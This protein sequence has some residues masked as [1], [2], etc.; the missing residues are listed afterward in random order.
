[1]KCF[2]VSF[3]LLL[4]YSFPSF[5]D[6]KVV[7][8]AV[9][10]WEPYTS[11]LSDPELKIS[12]TLVRRAFEVRGY[13]VE[14][15][16]YPWVRS[17]QYA[18]RGKFDGTFPWMKNEDRVKEFIFSEPFFSQRVQFFYHSDTLFSW[19]EVADLHKYQ[20]GA[21]QGYQATHV[22]QKLGVKVEI[23]NSEETNFQKMAKGRLDAYPTGVERGLYLIKHYVPKELRQHI[24]LD[25]KPLLEDDMFVI[26]SRFD[27][28]RSQVLVKEFNAGLQH[29]METG[30]Y[31]EIMQ[32]EAAF[33]QNIQNDD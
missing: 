23:N 18:I 10:D 26:F 12:E 24:K 20:I 13:T 4:L 32:S 16:Y 5:S 28:E 19:Q 11:S 27:S 15:E 29:L 1:M 22:M 8:F 21:T 31:S 17:Y 3:L 7:K 9:G 14:L 30:E 2:W 25:T 33:L 6:D